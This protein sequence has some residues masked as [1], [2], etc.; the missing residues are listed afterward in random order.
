M[1]GDE[2]GEGAGGTAG[3]QACL[4]MAYPGKSLKNVCKIY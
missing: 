2:G 1:K 3:R 4:N